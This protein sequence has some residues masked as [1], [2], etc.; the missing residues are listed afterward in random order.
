MIFAVAFLAAVCVF[1]WAAPEE[2][3]KTLLSA[4]WLFMAVAAI[5]LPILAALRII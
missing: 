1:V 3:T 4:A 2:L 5:V